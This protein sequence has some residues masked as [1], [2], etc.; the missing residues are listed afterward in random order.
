MMNT[1]LFLKIDALVGGHGVGL[2]DDGDDV[3]FVVKT[4]HERD[5]ER[6]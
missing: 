6:L 5:I 1:Y 3:D 2:G 4:L